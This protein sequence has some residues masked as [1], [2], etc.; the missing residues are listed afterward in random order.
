MKTPLKAVEAV[1]GGEVT[2]SVDLTTASSGEWFLD[3]A[4]LKFVANG[5]ESSIRMEVRGRDPVLWPQGFSRPCFP[6]DG[7]GWRPCSLR[8]PREICC[9]SQ[10]S[11]IMWGQVVGR[12]RPCKA[13]GCERRRA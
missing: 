12:A 1:E 10:S 9:G 13:T 7:V 2:F 3:G 5:I 6:R 11:W 8:D 4:E